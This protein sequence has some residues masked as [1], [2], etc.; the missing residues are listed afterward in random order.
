MNLKIYKKRI[1][2]TGM[3]FKKEFVSIRDISDGFVGNFTQKKAGQ[4]NIVSTLQVLNRK[5]YPS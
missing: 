5:N 2:V 1:H 4:K 3:H